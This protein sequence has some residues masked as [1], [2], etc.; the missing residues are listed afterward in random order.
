MISRYSYTSMLRNLLVN[1]TLQVSI[2]VQHVCGNNSVAPDWSEIILR[3]IFFHISNIHFWCHLI[4]NFVG[5]SP[6]SIDFDWNIMTDTTSR[7]LYCINYMP[8]QILI[9]FYL[10]DKI[11]ISSVGHIFILFTPLEF[12]KLFMI[13]GFEFRYILLDDKFLSCIKEPQ[14]E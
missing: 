10:L 2:T 7:R 12:K 9:A 5:N 13:H 11:Y 4:L 1:H 3:T 8:H 6:F 14:H